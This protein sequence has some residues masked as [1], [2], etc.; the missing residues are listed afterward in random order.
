MF[1]VV[2][3]MLSRIIMLDLHIFNL[4]I[5]TKMRPDTKILH[6]AC[7]STKLAHEIILTYFDLV[8]FWSFESSKIATGIENALPRRS[9]GTNT[10]KR[11]RHGRLQYLLLFVPRQHGR[12][13]SEHAKASRLPMLSSTS[14]NPPKL[15]PVFL[16]SP[17]RDLFVSSMILENK[18]SSEN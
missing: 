4:H 16:S 11:L 2:Q 7:S 12:S 8:D 9:I 13:G 14:L 3:Y 17:L 10:T 18:S 15:F 6:G 5:Q 1:I